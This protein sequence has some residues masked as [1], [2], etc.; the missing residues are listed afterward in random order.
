[1]KTSAWGAL[2][3]LLLTF[4]A[5]AGLPVQAA[6]N[7]RLGKAF[8]SPLFGSFTSFAIGVFSV[9]VFVLISRASAPAGGFGAVAARLPWW[10]FLGG[11]IGAVFVSVAAAFAGRLGLTLFSGVVIG[12]QLAASVVLDHFGVLVA[13][14]HPVTP[15]RLFGIA[16]LVAGIAAIRRG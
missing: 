1:M 4:V 16:L 10:L 3:P 12:G 7:N 15:M 11:V 13:E 9:F 2:F 5:G 8:G 14:R 6:L